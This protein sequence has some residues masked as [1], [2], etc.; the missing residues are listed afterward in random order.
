MTADK[1][2]NG[3]YDAPPTDH[4]WRQE[5]P[6]TITVDDVVVQYAHN[7]DFT[8]VN[9]PDPYT[10]F[11]VLDTEH[12]GTWNN[13]TFSTSGPALAEFTRNAD[14]GTLNGSIRLEGGAFGSPNPFTISGSGAFDA[15]AESG[16]MVA[17]AP[18]TGTLDFTKGR[19]HGTLAY[20]AIGVSMA[21]EGNY[22]A[23]QIMFT[24]TM[25]GAFTANG[26]VVLQ[27]SVATDVAEEFSDQEGA[28]AGV[29][30]Y[31]IPAGTMLT[32]G[33]NPSLGLVRTVTAVAADGSSVNV[34]HHTSDTSVMVDVSNLASGP[35]TLVVDQVLGQ[36]IKQ[37]IVKR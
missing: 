11:S 35:Y 23:D 2:M 22:G 34:E 9:M 36:T 4:A 3:R 8:D 13:L 20:T 32:L 21:I 5:I 18:L 26:W 14:A 33:V 27:T 19:V 6:S 25:S 1:N 31:P 7:T 29:Q 17:D 28:R 12:L 10:N 16:Q 24:Y 30:A 15:S 37:V